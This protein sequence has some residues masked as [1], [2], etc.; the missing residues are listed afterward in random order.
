MA[1]YHQIHPFAPG[2]DRRW[3]AAARKHE[4][5]PSKFCAVCGRKQEHVLHGAQTK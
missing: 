1:T 5:V 2:I 4:I 3:N